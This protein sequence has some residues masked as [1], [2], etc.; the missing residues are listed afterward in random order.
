MPSEPSVDLVP[1]RLPSWVLRA[2]SGL[3]AALFGGGL[4]A[5]L[6]IEVPVSVRCSFEMKENMTAVLGCPEGAY[7]RIRPAQN[8]ALLFDAFPYPKH[9]TAQGTVAPADPSFPGGGDGRRMATRVLLRN[10]GALFGEAGGKVLPGMGGEARVLIRHQ[11]L[12]AF[13]FSSP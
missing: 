6:L 9:G 8:V 11:S 4:V 7:T 1:P 12:F 3:M 5:S 2:V 10:P 13:V